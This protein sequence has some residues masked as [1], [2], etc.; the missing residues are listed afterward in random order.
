MAS[1]KIVR[2]VK[3]KGNASPD[4]PS[5]K[6]Y[7]TSRAK[8]HG[9]LLWEKNSRNYRIAVNQSWK[10]PVCGEPLFNG[11]A[12]ETHHIVSVKDG[13]TD[14]VCNLKHLHKSCHQ[15]V[16]GHKSFRLG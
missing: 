4:D 3:V 13:G 15:Q 2:H 9:K 5:L 8:K 11:E 1:T 14:E 10:C 16:H 7:W 6:E 12:I